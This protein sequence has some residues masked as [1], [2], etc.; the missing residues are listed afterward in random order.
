MLYLN[1]TKKPFDDVNV[2]KAI[3]MAIDRDQIANVAEYGYTKPADV[4]GLSDAYPNYK[5]ADPSTLGD[6]W[7]TLQ[8]RQGQPDA[9][10]CRPQEGRRRHAHYGRRLSFDAMRSTWLTAGPTGYLL[11]RSSHRA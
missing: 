5:V 6:D 1:T 4:T 9:R 3:S 10:R 11:A 7:T 8:R 2:R